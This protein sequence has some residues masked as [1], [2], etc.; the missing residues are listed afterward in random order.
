MSFTVPAITLRD[1]TKGDIIAEVRVRTDAG[2]LCIFVDL[3]D[4]TLLHVPLVPT[5]VAPAQAFG[6]MPGFELLLGPGKDGRTSA[7]SGDARIFLT[8]DVHAIDHDGNMP[9]YSFLIK[10]NSQ[11]VSPDP[12]MRWMNNNGDYEGDVPTAA[13]MPDTSH[14]T[15]VFGMMRQAW[16]REDKLGKFLLSI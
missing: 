9:V 3:L 14:F 11:P 15:E 10:P 8:A 6:T 4:P 13:Q 7:G 2:N 16:L 12:S 5:G 1:P